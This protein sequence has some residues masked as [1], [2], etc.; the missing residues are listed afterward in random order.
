MNWGGFTD[1]SE[2]QSEEADQEDDPTIGI[3]SMVVSEIEP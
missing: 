3:Y 2:L 1:G